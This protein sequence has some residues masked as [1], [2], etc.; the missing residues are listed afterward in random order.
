[1]RS[2]PPQVGG[3]VEPLGL[4]E[5]LLLQLLVGLFLAGAL[6]VGLRAGRE[7]DVL[8]G[9]ELLPQVVV[10]VAAGARDRLPAVHQR[11]H[12]GAGRAPVGGGGQL[13]GLVDQ[14]LLGRARLA[15]L[16]VERGEVRT[17]A[18]AE[19][20]P[21]R[22]EPGPE[23]LVGLA[24]DAADRL[25]LLDDRLEPVA[26]RLPRGGLRGDLLRLRGQRLLACDLR[27]R[28]RRPSPPGT[29]RRPSRRCRPSPARARP[30]RRGRRR[31]RRSGSTRRGTWALFL[32][33]PG[34]PVC[35]FSRASSSDTS[36]ARSS[37]RRP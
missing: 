13:L 7:E 17:A 27:R 5:Q 37:Y 21:G 26:G 3:R 32:I 22:G 11:A 35:A 8:C 36:V 10:P 6:L 28:G 14:L 2:G 15:A 24:V 33:S 4:G 31:R 20:V 19:G 23:R 9:A 16:G 18:P 30:A 25:P 12:G 34:L 29:P 1:M